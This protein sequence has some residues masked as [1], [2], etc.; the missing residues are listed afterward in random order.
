VSESMVDHV[1]RIKLGDKWK[2]VF[3]TPYGHYKYLVILFG[4]INVPTTF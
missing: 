3:R 4:L 1:I 2:I